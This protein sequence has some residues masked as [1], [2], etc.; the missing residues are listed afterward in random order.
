MLYYFLTIF[1]NGWFILPNWVFYFGKFITIVQIGL[2]DGI[3][4]IVGLV[5]EVPSGTISDIFG[6]KITLLIGNIAII[7]SCLILISSFNFV[8]LLTGSIVMFIGFAFISGAKEALL[9]DSLIEIGKENQ[10]DEILGKISSIS[11]A[12]TIASIFIGGFLYGINPV[13]PFIAWAIFSLIAVIILIFMKEPQ[14]EKD[15]S[16]TVT[17]M[18]TIKDGVNSIFGAKFRKYLFPVLFLSMFIRSYEGVVRQNMGAYFGFNGETLGYII[19]ISFIPALIT[20]YNYKKI[21]AKIGSCNFE[22]MLGLIFLTA[23]S[24]AFFATWYFGAITFILIYVAQELARPFILGRINRGVESSHRA[25]AISTVSLLSDIP[26]LILV[27][28]F[29]SMLGLSNLKYLYVI[30]LGAVC[31]YLAHRL[32]SKIGTVPFRNSP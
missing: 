20:A 7:I 3:S 31:V 22:Y 10:Y 24:V 14:I 2:I 30:F 17:F 28:G 11:I 32:F 21:K 19:A 9:Y 1:L 6:K 18:T 8:H 5:I 12:T 25:T 23:F 27:I 4:K 15:K 13:F 16:K 26:Y 29:G